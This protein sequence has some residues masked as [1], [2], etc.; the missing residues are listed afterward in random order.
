MTRVLGGLVASGM[1]LKGSL[2]R[3]RVTHSKLVQPYGNDVDATVWAVL[4]A[5]EETIVCVATRF[6]V[7][8][9]VPVKGERALAD[10]EL[11]EPRT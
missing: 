10:V 5:L 1:N 2:S 3:L 9:A 4:V 11:K 6:E 8:P 7:I